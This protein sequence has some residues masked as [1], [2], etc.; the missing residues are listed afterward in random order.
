MFNCTSRNKMNSRSSIVDRLNFRSVTGLRLGLDVHRCTTARTRLYWNRNSITGCYMN[1]IGRYEVD[2]YVSKQILP[3]FKTF[4][5]DDACSCCYINPTYLEDR[6]GKMCIYTYPQVSEFPLYMRDHSDCWD[7]HDGACR[8]PGT[9]L[10]DC[11][12][13]VSMTSWCLN[14][15]KLT[16]HG[17]CFVKSN[18]YSKDE[19]SNLIVQT[20]I[21]DV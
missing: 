19:V 8:C 1:Y 13:D 15:S 2:Y 10:L 11:L 21:P 16:I 17:K 7:R 12:Y 9:Y 18:M 14:G 6:I 5:L 20:G 3:F 4:G